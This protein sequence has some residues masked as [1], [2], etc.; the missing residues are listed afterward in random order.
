M[1]TMWP[2]VFRSAPRNSGNPRAGV[3]G[4][5]VFSNRSIRGLA[6][7]WGGS[8]FGKKEL[9]MTSKYKLGATLTAAAIAGLVSVPGASFARGGGL[10][11]GMGGGLGVSA[12]ATSHIGGMSSSTG[13]G[14]GRAGSTTS[15]RGASGSVGTSGLGADGAMTV[16]G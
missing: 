11:G 2:D 10:G 4:T 8:R 1:R 16:T 13:F 14:G 12:G 6:A 7:P 9:D 15:A 5:L 3:L